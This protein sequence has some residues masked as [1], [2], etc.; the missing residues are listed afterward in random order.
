MLGLGIA[1]VVVSFLW[2][3]RTRHERKLW[4][5]SRRADTVAIVLE[6]EECVRELDQVA[7]TDR[8]EAV[9]DLR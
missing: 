2:A 7:A 5:A 9:L 1:I 8:T 4:R 6:L 3:R